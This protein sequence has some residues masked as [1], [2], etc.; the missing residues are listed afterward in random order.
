MGAWSLCLFEVTILIQALCYENVSLPQMVHT[1]NI[2]I[3]QP[4]EVRNQTKKK[5]QSVYSS[6]VW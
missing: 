6:Y 5:I 3:P 2:N 1:L 4:S